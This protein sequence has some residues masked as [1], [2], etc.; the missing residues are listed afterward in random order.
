MTVIQIRTARP[1]DARQLADLAEATF[2]DTFGAANTAQDMDLHCRASYG[3]AIQ[4]AEIA[5]PDMLTLLGEEDGR[6]TGFAQLRWA[7]APACVAG[8]AAGEI[9][10]LY[11]ARE[12]HGKGVAQALMHACLEAMRARGSEV[13]WLGVW[14]RNPRAI[15]FYRKFGFAHVGEHVFAVGSDP[16][17]D[18]VMARPV[19]AS[20]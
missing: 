7:D 11:V 18:I 8:A 16:Q 3:E 4:A 5:R 14:E 15:A 2:R 1:D 6:L 17:R 12:W 13:V 20:P 9:Q 19:S 10:R